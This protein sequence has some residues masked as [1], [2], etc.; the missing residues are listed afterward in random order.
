MTYPPDEDPEPVIVT[1]GEPGWARRA[2]LADIL[3][4]TPSTAPSPGVFLDRYPGLLFVAWHLPG[5]VSVVHTRDGRRFALRCRT[6][7]SPQPP[8]ICTRYS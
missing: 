1:V 7:E 2:R 5:G 8:P 6:Q 3:L 4:G